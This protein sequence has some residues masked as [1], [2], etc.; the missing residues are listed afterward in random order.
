[1]WQICVKCSQS[2]KYRTFFFAFS[3]KAIFSPGVCLFRYLNP[4]FGSKIKFE[5]HSF[6]WW[7]SNL[8]L[9]QP[10]FAWA[11]NVRVLSASFID[12]F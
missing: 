11:E 7:P 2:N 5:L 8:L 12:A 9:S 6:L 4:N 1:M 10:K 3:A